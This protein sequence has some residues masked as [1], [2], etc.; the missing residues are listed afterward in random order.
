[1]NTKSNIKLS[2]KILLTL[3]HPQWDSNSQPQ[4]Y[5]SNVLKGSKILLQ[6]VQNS[7]T[8]GG[9]VDKDLALGTRGT[10]LNTSKKLKSENFDI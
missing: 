2:Y 10:R 8:L 7:A 9:P 1:M 4:D 6:I 3:R 5:K